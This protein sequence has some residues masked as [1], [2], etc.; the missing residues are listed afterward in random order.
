MPSPITSSLNDHCSY[1]WRGVK[2]LSSTLHASLLPAIIPSSVVPSVSQPYR[3]THHVAKQKV[4]SC[5]CVIIE[6]SRHEH[7]Q[8]SSF[9]L[10]L[11]TRRM[12]VISLTLRYVYNRKQS[13]RYPFSSRLV[14]PHS[15][16]EP[17]RSVQKESLET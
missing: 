15:R 5:L 12:C 10:S 1:I 8:Y 11:D 7:L 13:L 6:A 14:G 3:T 4:T 17:H 9:S 16:P 2:L